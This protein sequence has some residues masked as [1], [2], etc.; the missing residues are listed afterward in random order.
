MPG[1]E[2]TGSSIGTI[3]RR[4]FGQ[5]ARGSG[6]EDKAAGTSSARSSA[7]VNTSSRTQRTFQEKVSQKTAGGP[8]PRPATHTQRTAARS[9]RSCHAADSTGFF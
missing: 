3:A 9:G 7:P 5:E 1:D 6:R 8:C 4:D 2:R